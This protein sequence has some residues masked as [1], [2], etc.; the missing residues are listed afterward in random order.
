MFIEACF[1]LAKLIYGSNA[2]VD[3][4]EDSEEDTSRKYAVKMH[5]AFDIFYKTALLVFREETKINWQA[6]RDNKLNDYDVE[7]LFTMNMSSIDRIYNKYS[8][9]N[10]DTRTKSH[11][12]EYMTYVDCVQ[13][14][15]KDSKLRL[16][17]Y[18]IR[19]AYAMSKQTVLDELGPEG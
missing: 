3:Q 13:L 16:S 17:V 11:D 2:K 15:R 19:E 12:A 1:R 8:K 7:L 4:Y 18:V 10:Q 14:L 5:Q 9:M 6:F